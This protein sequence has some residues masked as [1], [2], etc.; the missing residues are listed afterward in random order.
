M[1]YRLLNVISY[2]LCN[3]LTP[4]LLDIKV[5]SERLIGFQ[6]EK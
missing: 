5:Q 2:I 1:I 3:R 4:C 6:N